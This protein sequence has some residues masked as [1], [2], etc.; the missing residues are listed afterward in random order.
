ML[1]EHQIFCEENTAKR[2]PEESNDTPDPKKRKVDEQTGAGEV[3]KPQE[4]DNDPCQLT[5]AFK[6]SLKKAT[7]RSKT[8]Y[9]AVSMW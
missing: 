3:E 1:L 8:R 7:K 6:D 9:V 5:S 2:R 4:D